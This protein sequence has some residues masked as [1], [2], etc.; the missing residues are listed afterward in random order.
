MVV[1]DDAVQDAVADP[2]RRDGSIL[3]RRN[4][5]ISPAQ[6]AE[7]VRAA[8]VHDFATDLRGVLAA[9]HA[10]AQVEVHQVNSPMEQLLV[11][12]RENEPD[13]MIPFRLPVAEGRGNEYANGPPCA[14]H[15]IGAAAVARWPLPRASAIV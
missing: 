2:I 6:H 8:F 3:A 11:Q 13:Q 15:L 14:G 5:T 7:K 12:S 1:L 10:P 9:G 4:P